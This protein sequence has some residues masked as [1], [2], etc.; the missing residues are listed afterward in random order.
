LN[1]T[2]KGSAPANPPQKTNYF[3]TKIVLLERIPTTAK[4]ARCEM[5]LRAER[6]ASFVRTIPLIQAGLFFFD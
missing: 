2:P 5:N 4:I 1:T 6:T 3:L